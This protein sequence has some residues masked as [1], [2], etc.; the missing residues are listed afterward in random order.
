MN[1][2]SNNDDVLRRARHSILVALASFS[3]VVGASGGPT[4][5]AVRGATPMSASLRG[6]VAVRDLSSPARLVWRLRSAFGV[7]ARADIL[8]LL[9][10]SPA[11]TERSASFSW[12]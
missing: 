9:L 10:S 2:E 7:N 11:G 12:S 1:Y 5:S 6:K 4:W 3:A 8:G